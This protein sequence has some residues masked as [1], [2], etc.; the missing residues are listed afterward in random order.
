MTEPLRTGAHRLDMRVEAF[1]I[2]KER[3][4]RRGKFRLV[5]GKETEFYLDMKPTMFHPAGAALLGQLLLEK[6]A[7]LEVD[8][9]G[10]LEL[11]AVPLVVAVAMA[12]A[13][14]ARPIAGFFVRKT[15]KGH[16]TKK[17]VEAAG[18]IAG[19]NVVILDDV[20]TTGGSAMEAVSAA[21]EAGANVLLVLSTVDRREGATE[22]YRQ[23]GIP[24]DCLFRVDEFLAAS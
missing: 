16:G 10:G 5:S 9:I 12:S 6:I 13:G 14:S 11:G 2:I 24:F 1:N 21:R 17:L 8:F 4:F 23:Q 20:T 22:F 19:K 15:V 3:S 7:G 18:D